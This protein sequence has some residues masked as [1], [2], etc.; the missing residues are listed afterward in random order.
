MTRDFKDKAEI[1]AVDWSEP[2]IKE[3]KERYPEVKYEVGDV[4]K[5]RFEDNFFDWV[6]AGELIEHQEKPEELI[7][8]LMR[9]LKSGG[10]L[11]LSTPLEEA[12]NGAVSAEHL[13][14]FTTDDIIKLLMD[15]GEVSIQ[16]YRD[17]HNIIIAYC[18]KK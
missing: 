14:S 16:Y 13:W 11:V 3:L 2:L 12:V 8:E 6:V 18:Q 5:L 17:T 1:Y 15:Y 9:V 10:T 7:K 4:N